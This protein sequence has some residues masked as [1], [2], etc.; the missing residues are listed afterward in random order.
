METLM[1]SAAGISVAVGMAWM[2]KMVSCLDLALV[3]NEAMLDGVGV[4]GPAK[5]VHNSR[6]AARIRSEQNNFEYDSSKIIRVWHM[7]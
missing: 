5:L 7:D 4:A 2:P 6:I 1:N 3:I